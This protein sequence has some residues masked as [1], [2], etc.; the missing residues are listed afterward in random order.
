MITSSSLATLIALFSQANFLFCLCFSPDLSL[1]SPCYF[2]AVFQIPL[3]FS[4]I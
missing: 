2:C 1:F 4:G 3:G